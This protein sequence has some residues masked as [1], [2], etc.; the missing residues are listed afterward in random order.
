MNNL[1]ILLL[2]LSILTITYLVH[3]KKISILRFAIF[4]F[5]LHLMYLG[6]ETLFENQI[7]FFNRPKINLLMQIFTILTIGLVAQKRQLLM[8]SLISLFGLVIFRLYPIEQYQYFFSIYV[9]TFIIAYTIR[10]LFDPILAKIKKPKWLTIVLF[11]A[12][13]INIPPQIAFAQNQ[14][15]EINNENLE[16][17]TQTVADDSVLLEMIKIFIIDID[18]NKNSYKIYSQNGPKIT[19]I[20]NPYPIRLYAVSKDLAFIFCNEELEIKENTCNYSSIN[21][22]TDAKVISQDKLAKYNVE[23]GQIEIDNRQVFFIPLRALI[24]ANTYSDL[25]KLLS[26]QENIL[27]NKPLIITNRI[28]KNFL[29]TLAF[30]LWLLVF[31]EIIFL[32]TQFIGKTIKSNK[33]IVIVGFVT[34]SIS[35]AGIFTIYKFQMQENI[36]RVKSFNQKNNYLYNNYLLYSPLFQTI[37]NKSYV[38]FSDTM[39]TNYII[40]AGSSETLAELTI[41]SDQIKQILTTTQKTNYIYIPYS[42]SPLNRVS[43]TINCDNTDTSSQLTLENGMQEIGLNIYYINE[44]SSI[45]SQKKLL[46]RDP[47]CGVNNQ[48]KQLIMD[49]NNLNIALDNDKGTFLRLNNIPADEIADL[50]FYDD[51]NQ[52]IQFIYIK[53]IIDRNYHQNISNPNANE[54]INYSVIEVEKKFKRESELNKEQLLKYIDTIDAI[55]AK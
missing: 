26:N 7:Y 12:M 37:S 47:G 13:L 46:F 36:N 31:G 6:F 28:D 50:K 34:L 20:D 43:I 8:L 1:D 19:S 38:D 45:G 27:V 10:S 11:A 4:I 30:S 21:F 48:P 22:K 44:F 32:N 15:L 25:K 18:L 41:N 35:L 5:L 29:Y 54:I 40:S 9:Y 24:N 52:P 2:I 17:S 23:V 51:N 42:E 39:M 53:N 16:Q 55:I 3:S 33:T 49:T 14:I